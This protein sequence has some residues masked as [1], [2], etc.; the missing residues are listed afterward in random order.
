MAKIVPQITRTLD[1]GYVQVEVSPPNKP[2][3]SYKLP[4]ENAEHFC[5]NYDKNGKKMRVLSDLLT[6]SFAMLGFYAANKLSKNLSKA[7]NVLSIA[8][9]CIGLSTLGTFIGTKITAS[10]Y[11]K[12]MNEHKAEEIKYQN[13]FDKII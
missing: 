12:F 3:R 8:V 7:L 2:V 11:K 4:T 1:N 13:E 9:G 10:N 5:N 6:F